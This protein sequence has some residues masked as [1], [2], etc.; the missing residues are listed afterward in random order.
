[1]G[2][3]SSMDTYNYRSDRGG[4]SGICICGSFRTCFAYLMKN[5]YFCDNK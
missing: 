1:V 5:G 4:A 2:R 3:V